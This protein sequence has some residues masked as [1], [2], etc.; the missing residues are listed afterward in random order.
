MSLCVGLGA[1]SVRVRVW[2]TVAGEVVETEK[3]MDR[4][5]ASGLDFFASWGVRGLLPPGGVRVPGSP[6][7][8]V[9]YEVREEGVGV[10]RDAVMWGHGLE[11]WGHVVFVEVETDRTLCAKMREAEVWVNALVV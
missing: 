1:C 10:F 2:M 9:E 5:R 7:A 4:L 3:M 11:E 8:V 6:G